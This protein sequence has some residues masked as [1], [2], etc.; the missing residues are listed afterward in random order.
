MEDRDR[1]AFRLT[2]QQAQ[3]RFKTK[4]KNNVS[5]PKLINR[6]AKQIAGVLLEKNKYYKEKY[7]ELG[8]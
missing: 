8:L 2:Q 6:E 3:K 7:K 5:R 4:K 1:Q